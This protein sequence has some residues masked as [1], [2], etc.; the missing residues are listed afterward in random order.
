MKTEIKYTFQVRVMYLDTICC[1]GIDLMPFEQARSNQI[2]L[3]YYPLCPDC[4]YM[5]NVDFVVCRHFIY[6]Q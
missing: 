4:K 3:A 5:Q 6:K 2:Q 1:M